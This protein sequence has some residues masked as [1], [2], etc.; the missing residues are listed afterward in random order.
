M[1]LCYRLN[2]FEIA[3]ESSEGWDQQWAQFGSHTQGA[4]KDAA[5]EYHKHQKT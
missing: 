1:I 5:T 3:Q 4:A 2:N